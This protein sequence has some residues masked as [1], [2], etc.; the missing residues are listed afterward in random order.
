[1]HFVLDDLFGC[2]FLGSHRW[3]GKTENRDSTIAYEG[4]PVRV[5]QAAAQQQA[6]SESCI[7]EYP[8]ME[9]LDTETAG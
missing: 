5:G 8:N 1:V 6:L 2:Y 9:D 3:L 4:A 7:I